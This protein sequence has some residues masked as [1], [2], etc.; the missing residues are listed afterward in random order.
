MWRHLSSFLEAQFLSFLSCLSG[1]LACCCCCFCS[2]CCCCCC[3]RCFYWPFFLPWTGIE[4]LTVEYFRVG[5][6]ALSI[7]LFWSLW[8]DN[9]LRD[10]YVICFGQRTKLSLG[11][12]PNLFFFI[13]S[14]M[15]LETSHAGPLTALMWMPWSSP[16][17]SPKLLLLLLRVLLIRTTDTLGLTTI[18]M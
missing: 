3:G 8:Y 15:I 12:Y 5:T 4:P 13:F 2:C 11:A 6:D 9:F 18:V 10:L 17:L 1:Y 14:L 16:F 7:E